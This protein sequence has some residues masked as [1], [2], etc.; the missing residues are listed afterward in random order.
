M[1]MKVAI[2]ARVS[3]LDQ[4]PEMQLAAL[5]EYAVRRGLEIVEEYVDCGVSGT[6]DRRPA[7]D[8]LIHGARQRQFDV[9]LVWKFDRF[10]RSVHHL[11]EALEEFRSLGIQFISYTEAIDTTT[12]LGQAMFTIISAIAALERDLIVE[13]VRAGMARA[14]AQGKRL[15]R[16]RANVD[17]AEVRA[18]R[19]QGRS[20]KQVA[21]QFGISKTT[22]I[23]LARQAVG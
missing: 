6:K 2:Y 22:V 10:A 5:R 9:V 11:I 17:A 15:G 20:L 12:A 1:A 13:R 3:T 4:N 21:D 18:L 16:P 14:K 19:A 7:L 23:R 8:R